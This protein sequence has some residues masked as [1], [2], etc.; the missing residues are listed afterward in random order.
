[1]IRV[2]DDPLTAGPSHNSMEMGRG[3]GIYV[4]DSLQDVNL[5]LVFTIIFKAGEHN[6]STICLQGQ[7][8]TLEKQREVAVVGGTGH[9]RHATGH[10]LFE[11]QVVSGPN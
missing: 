3:R 11:T 5:M 4:Q 10:A 8:D 9:F 6:G 2:I 1:M 7:D